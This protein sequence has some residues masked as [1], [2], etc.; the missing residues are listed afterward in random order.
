[1]NSENRITLIVEGGESEQGQV[2]ADQFCEE[3]SHLITTLNGFDRLVG[4][5]GKP[6]LYYRIVE[7]SKSSPVRV[8]LEPMVR[9]SFPKPNRDHIAVRHHRFF[10]ELKAISR[11]EPVS[12][13]LDEPILEHL[14]DLTAGPESSFKT[15]IISNGDTGVRLDQDFVINIQRLLNEA[16]SSY[17]TVEG[18]LDSVNIHGHARR[19]WIYPRVAPPKI[20]C[21]FLPGTA[22]QLRDAL[23]QYVRVEGFKYFRPQSPYPYRVAVRDF[24]ILSDKTEVHLKDL[25]GIAAGALPQMSSVEFVRAIR[26]EW[27]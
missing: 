26:D 1:M 14:R 21:D 25:R 2:R 27:D 22:D 24:E 3:L 11:N 15:V 23:G 12:P 6:T 16:D 10:Q 4:G 7:I 8:T 13:D 18:S 9:P 20:R 17:G 19:F 5:T